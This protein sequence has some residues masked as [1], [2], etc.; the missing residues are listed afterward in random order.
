MHQVSKF[1]ALKAVPYGF[2]NHSYHI[3]WPPLNATV[4]ITHLCILRDGSFAN[5]KP[6][7]YHHRDSRQLQRL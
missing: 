4:F 5:V 7:M 1:Y 2:E 6:Y 3:R